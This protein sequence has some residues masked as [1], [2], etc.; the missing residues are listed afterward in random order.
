[1][2]HSEDHSTPPPTDPVNPVP[3][4]KVE[5]SVTAIDAANKTVTISPVGG[6]AFLVKAAAT[7]RIERN[8]MHTTLASF[9]IGDAGEALIGADG[10]A[11]KIE[12]IG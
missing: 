10:F 9:H 1:M 12:A 3:T 2:A 6:P 8:G 7:T 5:G 4:T 11:T